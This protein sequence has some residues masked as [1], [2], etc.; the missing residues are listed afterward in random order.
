MI[1]LEDITEASK[2]EDQKRNAQKMA[3]RGWQ[4]HG[5]ENVRGHWKRG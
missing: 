4:V 3:R 5:N 1:L 2:R